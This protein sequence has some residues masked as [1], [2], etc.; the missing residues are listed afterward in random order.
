MPEIKFCGFRLP[1]PPNIEP[2]PPR[3]E[4]LAIRQMQQTDYPRRT[5]WKESALWECRLCSSRCHD[6]RRAGHKVPYHWPMHRQCSTESYGRFGKK[7]RND[8]N[9]CRLSVRAKHSPLSA[10]S[11]P[12]VQL[13]RYR[14]CRNR[15]AVLCCYRPSIRLLQE[16]I[17]KV[18]LFFYVKSLPFALSIPYPMCLEN[19]KKGA[20]CRAP[21][22]FW[23][24]L[25]S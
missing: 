4:S 8:Q 24:R 25:I 15:A 23:K 5:D 7:F 17:E 11:D 9:P 21:S 14:R 12:L 6:C 18:R 10:A 19:R 2:V 16:A 1:Y 22:A 3:R 20:L 13:P